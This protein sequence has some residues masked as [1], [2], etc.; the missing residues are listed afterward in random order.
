M[1]VILFMVF[2][3]T[4]DIK[5][6]FLSWRILTPI[7]MKKETISSKYTRSS[8]AYC[9]PGRPGHWHWATTSQ[10]RYCTVTST[11]MT[12]RRVWIPTLLP[13]WR[14]TRRVSS[15]ASRL[16]GSRAFAS[17]SKELA[18]VENPLFSNCLKCHL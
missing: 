15:A 16:P 6:V 13:L 5:A 1:V 3:R 11:R 2:P 18:A 9:C 12:G 8:T 7:R 17:L 4:L 14:K 10:A